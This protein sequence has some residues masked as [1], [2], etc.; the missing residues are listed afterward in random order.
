MIANV[1]EDDTS[2]VDQVSIDDIENK[3]IEYEVLDKT[4]SDIKNYYNNYYKKLT[5]VELEHDIDKYKYEGK[6]I[7]LRNSI[8]QKYCKLNR[9]IRKKKILSK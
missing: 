5:Y 9:K 4:I 3:T 6:N 1:F 2:I 7:E 8:I